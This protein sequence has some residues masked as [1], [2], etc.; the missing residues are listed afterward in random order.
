[1]VF[2]STPHKGS[3]LAEN[4]LGMIARRLANTPAGLTSAALDLGSN[5]KLAALRGG[6]KIPTAVDNMDWSNPGLRTL[7][8]LPIA[9]WVH[10]HSIIPVLEQPFETGEDGVVKYQSAHIEGVG[11]ELIVFPCGHST[12]GT[13]PTIEEVR[14]IL[15]EHAGIH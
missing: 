12:Q 11:S 6:W 4:W 3:Y 1:V 8:S 2:I 9:P 10:A 5:S 14:R 15:Y 7:Y 13:P